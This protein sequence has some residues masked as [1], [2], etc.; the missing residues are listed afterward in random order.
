MATSLFH[1]TD[2]DHANDE[3]EIE[4]FEIKKMIKRLESQRG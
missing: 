4:L 2:K 3:N 1:G